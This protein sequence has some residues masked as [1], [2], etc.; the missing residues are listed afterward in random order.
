M[1]KY[2]QII[3]ICLVTGIIGAVLGYQIASKS[4][5]ND[6]L[7]ETDTITANIEPDVISYSDMEKSTSSNLKSLAYEELKKELIKKEEDNFLEFVGM[8][9]VI[10]TQT[11]PLFIGSVGNDALSIKIKD[12]KIKIDLFSQ[13]DELIKS[14]IIEV[15]TYI[16]PGQ[17]IELRESIKLPYNYSYMKYDV[18]SAAL[19]E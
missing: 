11:G 7:I 4:E 10:S 19:V 15:N 3:I 9:G 5:N 18:I 1:K 13:S 14:T 17:E 8:Y 12:V 6:R 2:L 16:H